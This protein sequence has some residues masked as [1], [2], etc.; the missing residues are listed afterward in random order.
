M[1]INGGLHGDF[2]SNITKLMLANHGYSDTR[3][4][5]LS[6][7]GESINKPTRSELVAI[8]YPPFLWLGGY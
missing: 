6:T 8:N 3:A 7:K 2:N 5:D 1:F 4:V